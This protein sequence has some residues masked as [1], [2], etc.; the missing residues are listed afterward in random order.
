[1]AD[2]ERT[3]AELQALF[4]DNTSANI[5]PQDLR[6]FL[7][8]MRDPHGGYSIDTPAAT[9]IAVPGTYVKLAGT[10]VE[11]PH[12]YDYDMPVDNRIRYTED[13]DRHAV[14][15]AD[16]TIKTASGTNQL[17]ALQIALNGAPQARSVGKAL[18][19]ASGEPLSISLHWN[20]H[21]ELNDYLEIWVTNETSTAN[22]QADTMQL[23]SHSLF[24]D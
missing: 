2:T 14:V 8:T 6:D 1:M 4:A 19:K 17:I 22:V 9:T 11:D 5:S 20:G 18:L 13:I 24:G 12:I 23:H 15:S 7:V 21:L 16:V 10:T 3:L